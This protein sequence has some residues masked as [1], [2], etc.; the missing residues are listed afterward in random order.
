MSTFSSVTMVIMWLCGDVFKTVY[1]ILRFAPMQFWLC[2][3]IQI[4]VD[5]AILSQVF[6]YSMYPN[7]TTVK[8]SR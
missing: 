7:K 5:I 4:C 1:F 6:F 3:S 2:G 8:H